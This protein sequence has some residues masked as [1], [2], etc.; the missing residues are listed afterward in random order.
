MMRTAILTLLFCL[1]AQAQISYNP[2]TR[3][4]DFGL[5]KDGNGNYSIGAT[6]FSAA[7]VEPACDADHRDYVVRVRGGAGVADT[8]RI[9]SKLANDTYSWVSLGVAGAGTGD[10]IAANNLTDVAN[11][12]TALSNLGG[13]PALGNPSADNYVLSS[14]AA[15]VRSWVAQSGGEGGG[16]PYSGATQDVDLGGHGISA[17]F[18]SS[19]GPWLLQGLVNIAPST[20]NAGAFA[21]RVDSGAKNL[22]V[23]N[24]AGNTS[25][26]IYPT[27]CAVG[28]RV[29]AISAAGVVTC[30]ATATSGAYIL[31][32]G[33]AQTITTATTSYCIPFGGSSCSATEASRTLTMPRAVSLGRFT[34]RL[35]L[36]VPSGGAV[37]VYL[38]KNSCATSQTQLL[39]LP[40]GSVGPATYSSVASPVSFAVDDLVVVKIVNNSSG[41]FGFN[42]WTWEAQ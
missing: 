5:R 12:A 38:C 8:Y 25:A 31:T 28:E 39:S 30:T 17:A 42:G 1:T 40:A 33:G 29:S 18:F 41:G 19:P 20:P 23:L 27:T 21:V 22:Q 24:D 37:E 14:T 4:F 6:V 2:F 35:Q 32:S 15:G 16:V 11:A 36:A 26:T 34:I 10:L 9:C 13:E 7:T 3:R